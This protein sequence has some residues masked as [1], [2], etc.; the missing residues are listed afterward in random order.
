MRRVDIYFRDARQKNQITNN[1]VHIR[2]FYCLSKTKCEGY[3]HMKTLASPIET[4]THMNIC[5]STKE[6]LK[7]K[8]GFWNRKDKDKDKE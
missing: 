1:T 7:K 6:S 5:K 4:F 2:L 8:T 3:S